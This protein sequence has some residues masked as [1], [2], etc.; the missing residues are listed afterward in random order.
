MISVLKGI[1]QSQREDTLVVTVAGFGLQVQVPSSFL[2]PL[3]NEVQLYTHLHWNQE[4]GPSL[5]GFSEF[6][7]RELFCLLISCSGIGPRMGLAL[8]S[9]FPV[10]TLVDALVVGNVSLL[11]SVSGI[12]RKK[13]ETLIVHLKD[14]A[15]KFMLSMPAGSPNAGGSVAYLKDLSDA[16]VSLGYSRQEILAAV[17]QVRATHDMAGL[18]FDQLL[19]KSLQVL[20]KSR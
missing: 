3:G 18:P 11:S 14:K 7:Q 16:L 20:A 12:G 9:A 19:R 4:N 8:L 6:A 10:A 2:A 5:F 1:V 15:E 17:D 13:A